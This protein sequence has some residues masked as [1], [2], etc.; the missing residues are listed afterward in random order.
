MF[1][2]NL[3]TLN[4]HKGFSASG[5]RFVLPGLREAV[6]R[7][8][9]DLV[10]LQEVLGVHQRHARRADWPAVPQ[11]EYLADTLWTQYAYGRNAAYPD[12]HHG[13]ALL[14]RYPILRQ[15][16]RDATVGASE[17]RGLLHCVLEVPGR[18]L[19]VH[20]I[21]V[22]L[23]LR[24]AHRRRQVELLCGMVEREIPASAPLVVAGDFND[25]RG[26]AHRLLHRCGLREAFAE[27]SG[28]LARTFPARWPLLP[29][30][31]IY[32]RGARIGR[33]QVLARPPWS[34]LSDHA[35]LA[36]TIAVA[37]GAP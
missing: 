1:E 15:E 28:R 5:R 2:I 3:L 31:R 33:A 13:N 18:G 34:R 10:F 11:Y 26:A 25:W 35:A 12:G 37:G 36:A 7:V 24:E 30:D 19:E 32:V 8:G 17:K 4:V 14:S 9:A 23:G 20:A 29:L 22:H 6:R 27:A 16:N 21:C